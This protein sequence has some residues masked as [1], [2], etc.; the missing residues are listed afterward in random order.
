MFTRESFTV[1][2]W[3][4]ILSAPSAIGAMVVT[5]DPSGPMGLIHEFRAIMNSMKGYVDQHA[6]DN[7]LMAIIRDYMATKP[8]EEEE[9]QLKEWAQAQEAEAKANR[10]QTTEEVQERIRATVTEALSM[11]REK[12]ATDDDILVFKR[13]MVHVAEETANASKEGG[14]LG[15]GG[16]RVS[17]KEASVLA[18]IKSEMGV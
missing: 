18:Q 14:F 7:S 6:A 9:E 12:G 13:M 3:A 4:K 17:E 10:P 11:L 1:E 5:A 16:V 15:I 2:E 8:S